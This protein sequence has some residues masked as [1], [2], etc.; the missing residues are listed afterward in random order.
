MQPNTSRLFR[1]LFVAQARPW[2]LWGKHRLSNGALSQL[3]RSLNDSDDLNVLQLILLP[4]EII[5]KSA[6]WSSRDQVHDDA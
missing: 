4:T 2:D 3:E 5:S 1:R 6:N